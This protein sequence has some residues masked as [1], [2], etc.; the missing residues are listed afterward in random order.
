MPSKDKRLKLKEYNS[1]L[2]NGTYALRT[3]KEVNEG[4]VNLSYIHTPRIDSDDNVSLIDMTT[5]PDNIIPEDQMESIV[6][7]DQ[8]GK[9]SYANITSETE[10]VQVKPPYDIFPSKE[11]R[12]TREFMKNDHTTDNALYYKF[13]IKYHYDA[14]IG[15]PDKVVKYAGQQIELTDENGNPLDDSYKYNIYVMAMKDNPQIYWVKIY[16]H[17]NTDKEQTFKVRYNHVENV[18]PSGQVYS[19]RQSIELY[20]NKENKLLVA[21][22]S[23]HLMEGG[24]LRIINGVSSYEEVTKNEF[25]TAEPEDEVYRV[26]ENPSKGGYQ[27]YV[28]QRSEMDPRARQIFN[29]KI[30]AKYNNAK[31]KEESVT[32]GFINDWVMP[33]GSLLDFEKLEFTEDWKL[34]GVPAGSGKLD[35]KQM[36]ELALPPTTPFIPEEATYEILDAKGNLLYTSINEADNTGVTSRINFERSDITETKSE[37]LLPRPWKNAMQKNVRLKSLP[38]PNKVSVIA[39]RQKT[40]WDFAWKANGQGQIITY[41]NLT[42]NWSVCAM[43]GIYKAFTTKPLNVTNKDKWAAMGNSVE[44]KDWKVKN[45]GGVSYIELQENV[46][47]I[48]GLYQK[49]APNGDS[50]YGKSDYEFSVKVKVAD[51]AEDDTLGLLFRV[52]NSREYYMFIWERQKLISEAGASRSLIGSGGF[53][54]IRYDANGDYTESSYSTRNWDQYNE[55][56]GLKLQKKRI[57]KAEPQTGSRYSGY[58]AGTADLSNTKFTEITTK[59]SL[60]NSSAGKVG[61]EYNKEYKLTVVCTGSEFRIFINTSANSADRGTLVCQ[62]T[63]NSY[64]KGSVGIFSASCRPARW[65]DLVYNELECTEVCTIPETIVLSSNTQVKVSPKKIT[66]LIKPAMAAYAKEKYGGSKY[67][68]LGGYKAQSSDSKMVMDIDEGGIGYVYAQTDS[69]D[70]GG[71]SSIPWTT[72]EN[73][74]DINGDGYV[75]YNEDGTFTIDVGPMQLSKANIPS[76]VSGFKWNKPVVTSNSGAT[77]TMELAEDNITVS[78]TA[79][80]PP[81]V[82]LNKWITLPED[83]LLKDDGIKKIGEVYGAEGVYEKLGIPTDIPKEEIMLRLERGTATG[84]FTTIDPEYRV[85]YRFKWE[86]DGLIRM[87]VDHFKD[88]LGVNRFRLSSL[89]RDYQP[90]KY[91]INFTIGIKKD[92]IT[93]AKDLFASGAAGQVTVEPIPGASTWVVRDGILTDPENE[94]EFHGAYNT[95]FSSLKDHQT[96]FAFKPLGSDDDM[97]GIMFRVKDKNNFYLWAIERD[98]I[99]YQGRNSR[100]KD[101]TFPE[102]LRFEGENSVGHTASQ[103]LN[104]MGW[105]VYH[106]RVF[107]IEN[108]VKTCIKKISTTTNIGFKPNWQNNVRLRAVGDTVDIFFCYGVPTEDS[109]KPVYS[110]KTNW[111]A[112][113]FGPMNYSQRVEFLNISTSEL[114]PASGSIKNLENTGKPKQTVAEYTRQFCDEAAKEV[115]VK[116]GFARDNPYTPISYSARVISPTGKVNISTNGN[117]PLTVISDLDYNLITGDVGIVNWTHYEDLEAVPVF[118]IKFDSKRKIEIEKPKVEQKDMEIDN[119]YLRVKDGKFQ[120]RISLPYYEEAEKIPQIYKA[121]SQLI[122]FRPTSPGENSEVILEY[123]LPE[124]S[125]QE[126]YDLPT[127]LIEREAPII[128]NEYAIQTRYAPIALSSEMNI[129]YLQVEAIRQNKAK[130]LRVKDLD[131]AKGIIYLLDRVR[132][133]DELLVRYAYEE[134]WYT[135]RGFEKDKPTET[136]TMGIKSLAVEYAPEPTPPPI[137]EPAPEPPLP[138]IDYTIERDFF[139]L[140]LNPSPGHKYTVAHDGFFNNVPLDNEAFGYTV[141]DNSSKE[142]LVKPMNIYL[143]PTLIRRIDG[144]IIDGTQRR[145]VLQHTD[146]DHWFDPND[147]C[148]DLSL[149]RLAKV[150]VQANSTA[151]K[152]EIILDTRTRGGGLDEAISRAVISKVNKESLHHWDIGYFDGEA[153]QENGVFIIKLPVTILEQFH[154]S[155]VQAAVAKHKAYGNLPIIEYYDPNKLGMERYNLLDSHDFIEGSLSIPGYLFK[156]S[157]HYRVEIKARKNSLAIER[158]TATIE[159]FYMNGNKKMVDAPFIDQED[160]MIITQVFET[161]TPIKKVNILL[162]DMNV[163]FDYVVVLPH[164]ETDDETMEIHEI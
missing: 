158:E 102:P 138:P 136:S 111:S 57:Y 145:R 109:W 101:I 140:D 28:P 70:A 3:G 34:L 6:T 94:S 90:T 53:S 4:D 19:K 118:A 134:R 42:A 129:S 139:H 11:I 16:L 89:F 12:L 75:S 126:F 149:F 62:A 83:L 1:K 125:Y 23:R 56:M 114:I 45:S 84:P 103:F 85:N 64:P 164:S 86:K 151:E 8:T 105:G 143:R 40:K 93:D 100:M 5:I 77:V 43:G 72:E 21:G 133:Q 99:V 39:E 124:Y 68:V 108:G 49:V 113:S 112:G 95:K 127:T 59:D 17:M 22:S 141:Q 10:T 148:F 117:G 50:M 156:E 153:Y 51:S 74:L 66:E 63:D 35:A 135:Y 123:R 9:L 159:V 58:S 18:V 32:T 107:K 96:D 80:V 98:D 60:Y 161:I 54:Q 131:A 67:E 61:W 24:K 122:S 120:K 160:W 36:I 78:A 30:V 147:Y 27:V 15:E 71:S 152:D 163:D 116:A 33:V 20:T 144:T 65:R 13:E 52:K 110:V 146:A 73:G 121:Y 38:I 81:I 69:S 106:Q 130:R 37:D 46:V 48:A 162:S 142:L 55:E 132:E 97:I 154:E 128:L 2:S 119:W 82:Q 104:N 7:P 157:S 137:V 115:M 155:E 92:S 150:L 31:G 29:Y 44:P 79:A 76:H 25:N 91:E 14:M 41:K 47:D 87:P 88:F 26:I